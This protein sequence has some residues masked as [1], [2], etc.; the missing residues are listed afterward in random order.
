MNKKIF[1]V[2]IYRVVPQKATITLEL[3]EN[4]FDILDEEILYDLVNRQKSYKWNPVDNSD[5]CEDLTPSDGIQM[6]GFYDAENIDTVYFSWEK[7]QKE[8]GD[9]FD[10]EYFEQDNIDNDWWG[11]EGEDDDDDW[12]DEDDED[13]EDW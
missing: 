2:D 3:P 11:N 9:E 4:F 8:L 12:C 7:V 6:S 5:E 1:K 13:D 10:D